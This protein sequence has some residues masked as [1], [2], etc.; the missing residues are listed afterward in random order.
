MKKKLRIIRSCNGW[1]GVFFSY[2]NGELFSEPIVCW[3]LVSERPYVENGEDEERYI[4]GQVL[5][6]KGTDIGGVND[7]PDNIGFV[8]Y[9]NTALPEEEIKE[10]MAYFRD[11]AKQLME[12]RKAGHLPADRI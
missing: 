7:L 12:I 4:E 6:D 2:D 11:Q 10:R 3:A 1:V 5:I 9:L 8:G